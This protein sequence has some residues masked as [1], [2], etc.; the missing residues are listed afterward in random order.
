MTLLTFLGNYVH[1]VTNLLT[2]TDGKKI[3]T[4][5]TFKIYDKFCVDGNYKEMPEQSKSCCEK[6]RS[7]LKVAMITMPVLVFD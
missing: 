2:Q 3:Q 4:F 7:M 6:I 1:D 5:S